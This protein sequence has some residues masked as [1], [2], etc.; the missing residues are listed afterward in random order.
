MSDKKLSVPRT[1]AEWIQTIM[2]IV[3]VVFPA[4]VSVIGILNL[5]NGEEIINKVDMIKQI[6]VIV[7][8]AAAAIASIVYNVAKKS[9]EKTQ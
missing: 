6:A 8:S 2:D 7:L 4:I 5:P 3:T 1:P 9:I